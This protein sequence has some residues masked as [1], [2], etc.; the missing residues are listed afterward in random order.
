MQVNVWDS[1][2]NSSNSLTLIITIISVNDE[3]PRLTNTAVRVT[4]K[5]GDGP[6][7][8]LNSTAT[9]TDEDNCLEHQLLSE[10][11]VRVSSFTPGEDVL[12]DGKDQQIEFGP[13]RNGSFEFGSALGSGFG[14]WETGLLESQ[15]SLTCDQTLFP[16]CYNRLLR[17]LQYNNTASEP[18]NNNHTIIIEVCES[19]LNCF[20]TIQ[21][22]HHPQ[23]EDRAGHMERVEIFVEIEFVN[24]NDP[25]LLLDGRNGVIDYQVNFFEGQ[26]YLGGAVPVLLS[27]NLTIADNDTGPQI[28]VSATVSIQDSE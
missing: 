20:P 21:F 3:P 1:G 23:V 25:V 15:V 13:S 28:F 17:G 7:N 5:E 12:L 11:R 18:S 24:D 19:H 26:D 22:F 14:D 4:Y 10:I 2:Y 16:D 9:L 6:I 8:L 27:D